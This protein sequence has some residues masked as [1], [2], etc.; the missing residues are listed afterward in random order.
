MSVQWE[1]RSAWQEGARAEAEARD[2]GL[3]PAAREVR[4]V[5]EGF[6]RLHGYHGAPELVAV[7]ARIYIPA[8]LK[9]RWRR[10]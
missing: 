6:A 9:R 5:L 4:D 1:P 7:L 2:E 8:R 3:T 10:Q